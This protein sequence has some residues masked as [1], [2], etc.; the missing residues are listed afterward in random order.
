VCAAAAAAGADFQSGGRRLKRE[1]DAELA[2]RPKKPPAKGNIS[3][4]TLFV[5]EN[6]SRVASDHPTVPPRGIFG[7]VPTGTCALCF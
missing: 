7:E 6:Y 1:Y 5:R 3:G 2:A 4:W